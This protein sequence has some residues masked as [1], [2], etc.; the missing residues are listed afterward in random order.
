MVAHD[1]AHTSACVMGG[2]VVAVGKEGKP[3]NRVTSGHV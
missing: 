2:L 3:N 1:F